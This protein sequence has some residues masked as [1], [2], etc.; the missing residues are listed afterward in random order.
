MEQSAPLSSASICAYKAERELPHPAV[1]GSFLPPSRP[2]PAGQPH[3]LGLKSK[4]LGR[5]QL[6]DLGKPLA[7]CCQHVTLIIPV[8]TYHTRWLR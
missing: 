3:S 5:G 2:G 7:Y 8:M 1:L 6:C 4:G